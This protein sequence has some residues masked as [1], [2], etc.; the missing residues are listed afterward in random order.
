MC[1]DLRERVA[2]GV[3]GNGI[4]G[5]GMG[6]GL[7]DGLRDGLGGNEENGVT[8]FDNDCTDAKRDGVSVDDLGIG[9][10]HGHGHG[11]VYDFGNSISNS[12]GNGHGDDFAL[13]WDVDGL[14]GIGEEGRTTVEGTLASV[15]EQVRQLE[16]LNDM[17]GAKS[18]EWR[19]RDEEVSVSPSQRQSQRQ[20]S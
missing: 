3:A 13:E 11:R 17:I 20:E 6:D 9:H 7:G 12:N 5:H 4:G 19:R 16:E 15:L 18:G 14:D 1:R 10:G 2:R 8:T